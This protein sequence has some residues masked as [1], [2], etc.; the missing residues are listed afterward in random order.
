MGRGLQKARNFHAFMVAGQ[1]NFA[2]AA[3][4]WRLE[5]RR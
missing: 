3:M 2:K 4:S 5:N 1:I